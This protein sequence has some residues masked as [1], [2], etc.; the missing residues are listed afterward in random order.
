[1]QENVIFDGIEFPGQE[2]ASCN[3]ELPAAWRLLRIGHNPL[4]REGRPFDLLF[5]REDAE[6]VE[7]YF[8][9]KGEKIPIDSRHA[10]FALAEKSGIEESELPRALPQKCA[11][12]GYAGIE[13][14]QD[15]LWAV[16]VEWTALGAEM[17]RNGFFRYF[18]PVIRGMAPG[19]ILRISSIALDNVPALNNLDVIAA[20]DHFEPTERGI[21]TMPNLN[22]ALQ[23]L[24]GDEEALTL[25]DAQE[26]QRVAERILALAA[27]LP[28]LRERAARTD[29]LEEAAE[30]AERDKVIRRGLAAGKFC[31]AQR[32][33]L[34]TLALADLTA[35]EAAG[36]TGAVVPVNM[37][38]L[39]RGREEESG[40]DCEPLS[41]EER[42]VANSL[43]LTEKEFRR[44]KKQNQTK[45]L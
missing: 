10:L 21:A 1:M 16:E 29:A 32:P 27:E 38:P 9:G 19:G 23:K 12:L 11:A 2:I 6:A 3:G 26:T 24:L 5:S 30:N 36:R 33:V 44:A 39:E 34:E 28:A 17:I 43:N 13:A 35:L 4:T 42:I 15:G 8:R 14:R 7:R 41:P 18:S 31:N 25:G 22:E 20:S 37:L 40:D 45:E